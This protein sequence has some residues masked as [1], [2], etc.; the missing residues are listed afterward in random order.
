MC[1]KKFRYTKL[2]IS[3]STIISFYVLS[4]CEDI[5]SDE[6][7]SS[8]EVS[9]KISWEESIKRKVEAALKINASENYDL[10]IRKE[11][12][13]RDTLQDAVILVNRESHA[14]E[15][16]KKEN[17][18]NFFEKLGFTGPHNHVL[19]YLGGNNQ[20]LLT[21]PVGSSVKHPLEVHF[22]SITNPS[23]KDFYVDYRIRN[24]IQRNYYTVR[25]QKIYLTL[26]C[27]VLDSVGFE[28]PRVYDI[29]HKE[30]SVRLSKD[31]VLYEG[32]IPG[33]NPSEIA[34][35]NSYSPKEILPTD[36]LVVFFIFDDKT[37]T[38]K[39]PM[40]RKTPD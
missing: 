12:I 31:I 36:Q 28:K 10:Q 5:K 39:T 24:S 40:I 26:S 3:F 18:M 16:A 4:S 34:D 30:S 20:V 8:K 6:S 7:D 13:D 19:V 11:Y 23:L 15:M 37:M 38:Y 33:Y 35:I 21:T 27:P 32:K 2:F 17:R 14:M 25:D 22:E 1:L 29:Q 9:E